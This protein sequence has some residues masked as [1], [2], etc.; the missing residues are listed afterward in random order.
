MK[1]IR[2]LAVMVVVMVTASAWG[3]LS[4]ATMFGTVT[5]NTGAVIANATITLTQV[6][7]NFTRTVRSNE[8]GQYRAEF[9]P[10]GSYAAKVEASGFKA[11]EQKGIALTATQN[12]NLNF[13]LSIG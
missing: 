6:D 3:Q 7:T 10:I 4:T 13:T 12:A 1:L 11:L 8:Q 2:R 5:D 9:L